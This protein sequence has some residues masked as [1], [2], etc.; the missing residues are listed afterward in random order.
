MRLGSIIRGILEKNTAGAKRAG[1][2]A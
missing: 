2:A 1:G